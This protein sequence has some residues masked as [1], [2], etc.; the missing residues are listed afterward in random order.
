MSILK[1]YEPIFYPSS[2]AVVG[3]SSNPRKLGYHCLKSLIDGGYGGRIFPV[4]PGVLE[5]RGY[6]AYPS[7]AA[8]PDRVDLAIVAVPAPSVPSVFKEC[9]M[10]GVRGIVLITAGFR[11]IEDKSGSELQSEIAAIANEARMKVI[12][13]NTFGMVNLH[14]N[15]NAS[16]TPEFSLVKKGGIGLISQSGGVSHLTAYLSMHGNV[17]FSKIIG[18]GNR[19]NMDFAD[20][21][22]YMAEDPETK[23]IAMYIEGVDDARRLVDVA[24]K[25]T[26]RKPVVAYKV[27]R[28]P[29]SNQASYSHTGS[30]A[31]KYEIYNSA[32]KQAGV[33]TVYS[34]TELFD[35]AKALALCKIPSGNRVVILSGQA[36]PGIIVGD[37]CEDNG[38]ILTSFSK[39]TQEAVEKL[40]PPVAMRRNPIDLGPAWHDSETC[41][42][43][44]NVVSRDEN[45]DAIVICAAYASANEPLL[46]GIGKLLRKFAKEKTVIGSF[47]SPTNV[48]KKEKVELELADVPV[49]PTPERAAKALVGL[50]RYS[51]ALARKSSTNL[52]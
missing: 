12:G 30:L 6:K 1:E 13:P 37:V 5:I 25:V 20:M 27:G 7:I 26:A 49:Y 31:G 42:R 19:C 15:L 52:L 32:L 4:N 46:R 22:E 45:V 17:G 41:E 48:W 23:V 10:K 16:F 34:C 18:L 39:E 33:V 29:A 35:V 36:G 11:E 9:A 24:D 51:E 8:V 44:V 47:P 3:A 43:L 40:L 50:V 38:L 21:L 14:A 2:V 28:F